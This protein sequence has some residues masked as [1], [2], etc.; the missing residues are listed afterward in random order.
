MPPPPE[1]QSEEGGRQ[2][3]R[4]PG[5]ALGN[6]VSQNGVRDARDLGRPAA[7]GVEVGRRAGERDLS[8]SSGQWFRGSGGLCGK[9]RGL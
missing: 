9:E 5:F 6:R 3:G 8:I 4:R 2:R 7:R 1:M